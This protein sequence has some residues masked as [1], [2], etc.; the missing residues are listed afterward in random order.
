MPPPK[1]QQPAAS[2]AP[3]SRWESVEED[4]D[5]DMGGARGGFP[6]ASNSAPLPGAAAAAAAAAADAASSGVSE[7]QRARL[8]RVEVSVVQYRESLEDQARRPAR[9]A[10]R[11]CRALSLLPLVLPSTTYLLAETAARRRYPPA[12]GHPA[13]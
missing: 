3:L 11:D 5:I 10:K 9:P 1:Q 6:G 4:A 7:E 2:R 12:T 8:R 13:G